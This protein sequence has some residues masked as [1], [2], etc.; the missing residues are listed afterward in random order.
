M[1]HLNIA[2]RAIDCLE[3]H[4]VRASLESDILPEYL[5]KQRWFASKDTALGSVRIERE[6]AIESDPRSLIL[7]I[8]AGP[9]GKAADYQLPL[10]LL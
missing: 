5:R 2:S 8:S 7:I 6:I 1:P 3:D 10:T 4:S 9:P